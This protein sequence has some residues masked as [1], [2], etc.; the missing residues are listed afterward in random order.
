MH[1]TFGQHRVHQVTEIVDHGV[2]HHLQMAGIAVD[3]HFAQMRAVGEAAPRQSR[4]LAGFQKLRLTCFPRGGGGLQYGHHRVRSCG[5]EA[6]VF[7]VDRLHIHQT[8][9]ERRELLDHPGRR[10]A[11][12]GALRRNRP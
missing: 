4:G 12:R 1:L 7:E 6:A 2:F 8:G 10:R 3:F 5:A 11:V 9:D